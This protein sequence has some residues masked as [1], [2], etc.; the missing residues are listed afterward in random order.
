MKVLIVLILI[1][2]S[3]NCVTKHDRSKS[4]QNKPDNPE[5]T[6]VLQIFLLILILNWSYNQTHTVD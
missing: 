5:S 2:S 3:L 4:L 6:A 1:A